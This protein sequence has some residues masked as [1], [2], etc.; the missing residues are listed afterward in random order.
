MGHAHFK[1]SDVRD[2]HYLL[3]T[4][5]V[6]LDSDGDGQ[7]SLEEFKVLFENAEKRKKDTKHSVRKVC[8]IDIH[9]LSVIINFVTKMRMLKD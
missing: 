5:P 4:I 1:F 2:R 8:V 3:N 7:L 9:Q 6:Q